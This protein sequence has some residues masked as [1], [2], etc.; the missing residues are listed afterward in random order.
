[1]GKYAHM[2]E[3]DVDAFVSGLK[4]A[5]QIKG[6]KPAPLSEAAGMGIS[7]VRDLFRKNSSP[8]VSTAQAL[9]RALGMT[10]DEIIALGDG[11]PSPAHRIAVAGRVGAGASV[12]LEDPYP[13]GEGMFH[14]A[15]PS[16]LLQRGGIKGIVAVQVEGDSMAP[17]YQPGDVLF[18]SRA[19]HEGIPEEDIGRPCIVEDADGNAWVKQ[20]KRGD[21]PGLFHLISLNPTSETRH[22]QQIKWAARVRLAL[23]ADL[24]ER[25]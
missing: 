13:K 8:K 11:A 25:I 12:P 22:N 21:E 17:M 3:R 2:V 1:M 10:V 24:V 5:M 7:A 16:Q 9:A 4:T 15:A 18:Y 20:V 14:V 19:T 23:P 6:W